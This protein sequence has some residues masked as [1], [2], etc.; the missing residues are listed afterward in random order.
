MWD[1]SVLTLL[2][3]NISLNLVLLIL[4]PYLI[5]IMSSIFF[6]REK[7]RWEYFQSQVILP[8]KT[9]MNLFCFWLSL[10]LFSL[11]R[12]PPSLYTV[13]GAHLSHIAKTGLT[14]NLTMSTFSDLNVDHKAWLNY[15]AGI[16]RPGR[17]CHSFFS[18]WPY[19]GFYN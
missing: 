1:D 19:S 10:R 17:L 4:L 18:S 11:Y 12:S 8:L 14:N 6:F 5:Q 13:F 7:S 2:T 9:Q 3:V 15:S 16:D